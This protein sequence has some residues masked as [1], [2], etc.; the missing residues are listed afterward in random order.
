MDHDCND[1]RGGQHKPEGQ[2]PDR[3][4]IGREVTRRGE[5]GGREKERRQEEEEDDLR[6]QL[7]ARQAGHQALH[8]AQQQ[9]AQGHQDRVRDPDAPSG[10]REQRNQ[11]QERQDHL[12][13]LHAASLAARVTLR[14]R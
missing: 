10:K 13:L 2:Q 3:P 5:E 12:D 9:P 6:R 14:A 4:R 8:Q 11:E 1:H 7:D